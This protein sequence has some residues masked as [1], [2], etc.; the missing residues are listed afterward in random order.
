MGLEHIWTEELGTMIDFHDYLESL[1]IDNL[2]SWTFLKAHCISNDGTIISGTAQ[3]SFGNWVTFIIDLEDELGSNECGAELGD[4]NGD[5]DINTLD[6]VQIAYYI[7]DL[8]I[9][10][11]E[12]A[13]DYNQDGTVNI[14]DLVEIINFILNF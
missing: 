9:P 3:N 13:A 12:C 8:S 1:G 7:L 5:G 2:S 10:D 11:Y 6:L 4:V 14:I